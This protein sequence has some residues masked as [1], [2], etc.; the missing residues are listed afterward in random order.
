MS[1]IL[2]DGKT[3]AKRCRTELKQEVA[4]CKKGG[5]SVS[6]SVILVGDDPASQIYVRNKQ[7]ACE[8]V[9]IHSNTIRMPQNVT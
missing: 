3:V 7:R 9:G 4:T 5:I 8:E 2:I 1:A 6:L